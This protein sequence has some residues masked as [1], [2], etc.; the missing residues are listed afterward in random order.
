MHDMP[1]ALYQR[2][3]ETQSQTFKYGQG[4]HVSVFLGL[5]MKQIVAVPL[6]GHHQMWDKSDKDPL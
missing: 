1:I 5:K 4:L 3:W 2:S 6:S